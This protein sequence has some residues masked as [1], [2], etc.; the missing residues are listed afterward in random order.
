MPRTLRVTPEDEIVDDWPKKPVRGRK[1]RLAAYRAQ[2]EA[3]SPR[4]APAPPPEP[5]P[6]MY[7]RP[8]KPKVP[9][10]DVIPYSL[11]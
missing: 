5:S 9:Y 6:I 11:P 10:Q 1:G 8:V 7:A 4:R 2:R 3:G